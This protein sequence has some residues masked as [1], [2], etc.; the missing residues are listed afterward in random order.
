MESSAAWVEAAE[1]EPGMLVRLSN[2][3]T[4]AVSRVTVRELE[5]PES[6]YNIEVEGDHNYF[7]GPDGVLVHNG[8]GADYRSLHDFIVYRYPTATGDYYIGMTR[9]SLS[10]RYGTPPAGALELHSGLTYNQARGLEQHYI[11][12]YR[13][14]GQLANSR[15]SIDPRRMDPR[16]TTYRR[17]ATRYLKGK[18][19]C[20]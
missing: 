13:P 1:L 17:E 12:Q 9:Q 15:N 4:R 7:V 5:K 10:Y 11:D 6:T 3:Q 14:R 19:G 20:P 18:G 16:A 8:P 2:G